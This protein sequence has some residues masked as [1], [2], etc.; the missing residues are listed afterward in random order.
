MGHDWVQHLHL[1]S[2]ILDKSFGNNSR[3]RI[4]VLSR[5]PAEDERLKEILLK[6]K[7]T[8]RVVCEVLDLTKYCSATEFKDLV[9]KQ[10]FCRHVEHDRKPT[11]ILIGKNDMFVRNEL[12]KKSLVD[13]MKDHF[14]YV[15]FP[16]EK[17]C[18]Y[19][20]C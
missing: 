2:W 17:A 1:R 13:S 8:S 20:P 12:N 11:L 5:D 3:T 6:E 16:K 4:L 9:T 10:E 18:V 15:C 7:K 19:D 14:K